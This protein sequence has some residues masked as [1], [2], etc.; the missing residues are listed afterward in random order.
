MVCVHT[1]TNPKKTNILLPCYMMSFVPEPSISF[2]V[3]WLHDCDICDHF[4]T[5]ET[6]MCNVIFFYFFNFLFFIISTIYYIKYKGRLS[7]LLSLVP[8]SYMVAPNRG[9]ANTLFPFDIFTYLFSFQW[10]KTHQTWTWIWIL[11]LLEEDQLPLALTTLENHQLTQMHHLFHTIREWKFKVTTL[12]GVNRLKSRRECVSLFYILQ[13]RELYCHYLRC[14]YEPRHAP[15][16][17][18]KIGAYNICMLS[19]RFKMC[20]VQ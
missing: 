9:L 18:L 19:L 2:Y 15:K 17:L 4:V 10:L 1:I 14:K 20:Q 16:K 6:I 5:H 12:Y 7:S 8:P 3:T 11:V 13:C